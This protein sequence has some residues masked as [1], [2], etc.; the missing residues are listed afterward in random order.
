MFSLT[1]IHTILLLIWKN[2]IMMLIY[3]LQTTGNIFLMLVIK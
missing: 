1:V 3:L 2:H